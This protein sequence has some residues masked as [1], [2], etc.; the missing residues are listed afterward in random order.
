MLI[1]FTTGG[2]GGGRQVAEYLTREEG[3][4]HAPPEVVRGDMD[5]TRDLI[6][7]ISRQ[8]SYTHGVLSFA[9]EDAPTPEQQSEAMTMFEAL[10]FAG[11]DREQYDITW[12]RHSHTDSG[13]VELHFVSPRMELS[14]GK[15][16]NIAPP[17][18]ESTYATLRDTLNFRHDWARPDDPDRARELR[19]PSEMLREG[20]RLREGREGIHEHLT[21]LVASEVVLDRTSMVLAIREAGL[22]VTREGKDYITVRDPE[23]DERF[24]MKGRIYEKDW[25]Y[26]RELD[27]ALTQE[28]R[29]PDGRDR[30]DR[31]RRAE[32]AF[33]RYQGAVARRISFNADRYPRP[34]HDHER[35]L[36]GVEHVQP[37]LGARSSRSV[38]GSGDLGVLLDLALDTGRKADG[39]AQLPDLHGE[40]PGVS[41]RARGERGH[42]LQ[43]LRKS[44]GLYPAAERGAIN[45]ERS[46]D[47]LRTRFA[48]AIRGFGER[49]RGLAESIHGHVQAAARLIQSAHI[50]DYEVGKAGRRARTAG[51]E[52]DRSLGRANSAN[53]SMAGTIRDL[54]DA[55][56]HVA[57]RTEEVT[58][59]R[60]AREIERA[61]KRERLI[62]KRLSKD[63]GYE[64]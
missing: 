41:D 48:L 20:F 18:W 32:E 35:G 11:L 40:R 45:D 12:V 19:G 22:D 17:H 57:E 46:T 4:G 6:D 53:R 52:H 29:E 61:E 49:V 7:S 31:Q 43:E 47:S 21:A 42:E 8:W 25:T 59:E 63:R 13:R 38:S 58:R 26:D 36:G 24:R 60:E 50:E 34:S 39:L 56:E 44:G 28:G 30:E 15:A 54:S 16:L 1:K 27:R 55:S 5:R 10:A 3:R 37:P 23:S 2:R 64:R 62:E 14:G 9:P 51:A 33:E